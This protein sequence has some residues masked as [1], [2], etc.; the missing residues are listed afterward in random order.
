MAGNMSNLAGAVPLGGSAQPPVQAIVQG[1]KGPTP[2]N[3]A[4]VTYMVANAIQQAAELNMH[5]HYATNLEWRTAKSTDAEELQNDLNQLS[6]EGYIIR[7]IV[8]CYDRSVD[9]THF[10]AIAHREYDPNTVAPVAVDP[11]ETPVEAPESGA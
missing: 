4:E 10:M 3:V 11:D 1:P 7:D 9:L 5:K 2:V 6:L 8:P